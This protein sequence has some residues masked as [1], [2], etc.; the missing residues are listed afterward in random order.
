MK[1]KL[2][3]L[4]GGFLLLVL[5]L[6]GAGYVYFI[7]LPMPVTNGE[8]R[9]KGLQ[10]SVTVYRDRWSVPHIYAENEHDLFMAQGY[11]QAQDRLWQ[12]ETNRRLAAG[13]LSEIFG[14]DGLEADKVL[15]SLGFMRAARDEV[16]S[17]H[18][19]AMGILNAFSDGVNG[20][21]ES[22][23]NRLPL[24][25]RILGVT[26]E[27]WKP[28]DSMG[29]GKFMAYTGGKNWQEEIVRAML[30]K[31]LGEEKANDLLKR[32]M[33]EMVAAQGNT[34]F[35]AFEPLTAVLQKRFLPV[36]G[37]ASNNW[38]VHGSRTTT[39]L[40]LLANDMHL[41][42]TVPSVL[43][44]M[45]LAGGELDVIG[46]SLPGVPLI[47]AGHNRHLAWG[48]TFAYTDVQDIFLE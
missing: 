28:E 10:K 14:P 38:V 46:V 19:A 31:E 34:Q 2:A 45:H 48:I 30:A 16:A 21:I 40:P 27:P 37:G 35:T 43:Y 44:E 20:F 15:R 32:V 23:G 36:F 4:F 13:R 8:L 3:F 12:M 6:A 33:P 18:S 17:Y 24:E 47:I 41:S 9:I 26:P 5:I 42:M 39:G 11:V 25:F 22:Q 7:R 1:K 29:W